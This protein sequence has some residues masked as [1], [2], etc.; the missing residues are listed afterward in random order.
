MEEQTPEEP[1]D[2]KEKVIEKNYSVHQREI[3]EGWYVWLKRRMPEIRKLWVMVALSECYKDGYNK[4]KQVLL[5]ENNELKEENQKLRAS[6][7]F[8]RDN[9]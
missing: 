7:E 6:V 2:F 1:I 8:L 4:A 3:S 5:A 9:F